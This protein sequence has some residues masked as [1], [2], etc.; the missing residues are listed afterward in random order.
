MR[1]KFQWEAGSREV[2][3]L[4]NGCRETVHKGEYEKY[5]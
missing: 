5:Y 1:E 4:S 3:A 2:M